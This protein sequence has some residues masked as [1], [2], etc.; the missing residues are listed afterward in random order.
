MHKHKGSISGDTREMS[1][2]GNKASFIGFLY[3]PFSYT[4][5]AEKAGGEWAET[6]SGRSR[7]R[8]GQGACAIRGIIA[9]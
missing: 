3:Y 2:H 7:Q 8:P 9:G 4:L 5:K 6:G 1:F